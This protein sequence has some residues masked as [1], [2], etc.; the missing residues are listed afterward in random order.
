MF[1]IGYGSIQ[2]PK[3]SLK[4]KQNMIQINQDFVIEKGNS[5]LSQFESELQGWEFRLNRTYNAVAICRWDIQKIE[6]SKHYINRISDS[7]LEETIY[8]E[9]AHALA[10]NMVEAHG[11]E[12]KQIMKDFGYEDASPYVEVDSMPPYRY[13]LFY[14]EKMLEG[15]YRK[16]QKVYEHY[17]IRKL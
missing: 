1:E 2:Q 16:P 17:E 4:M 8:H 3:Y 14:G 11:K 10:G 9:I 15:F 13:G 6:F 7:D 12:W 5:I